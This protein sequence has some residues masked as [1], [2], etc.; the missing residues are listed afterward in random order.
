M[1]A[2]LD[3]INTVFF[4]FGNTLGYSTLSVLEAW[5]A[6]AAE[7]GIVLQ[8]DAL[9]EAMKAAD[10][11]YSPKVYEYRGRMPEFWGLYDACVLDRL[12]IAD[13]D[14]SLSR[15]VGSAFLDAGRL[16][17]VFPETHPVLSELK[18]RGYSLGIISNNTDEMLDRMKSLGLVGY[19]DT[20]TY[21]QEAGAEKPD[22]APFELALRRAGRAPQECVHIGD[23]LEQD[24]V[25]ARGVGIKPILIDRSMK[26]PGTDCVTIRSLNEILNES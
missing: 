2:Y 1:T 25:G 23:S 5:V 20:V 26:Y 24:I 7:R 14:G 6:A 11:I 18:Q 16:F 10:Q 8:Q 12:G 9:L 13:G 21:S 4:D 22:P 15:A 19:F 3:N 17:R